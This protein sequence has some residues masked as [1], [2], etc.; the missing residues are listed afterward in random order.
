MEEG[1]RLAG[2]CSG[3]AKGAR[4]NT[5]QCNTT[6]R[7][8]GCMLQVSEWQLEQ[9]IHKSFWTRDGAPGCAG[10]WL[11]GE[12]RANAADRRLLGDRGTLTL[13]LLL[14]LLLLQLY[15]LHVHRLRLLQSLVERAPLGQILAP[16]GG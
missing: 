6:W 14:L 9:H 2:G 7:V 16:G 5:Q 12:H 11:R 4:T 8:Q 15:I 3:V 10:R 13:L 1:G